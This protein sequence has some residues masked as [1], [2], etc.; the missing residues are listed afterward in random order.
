MPQYGLIRDA[1]FFE[2]LEKEGISGMLARDSSTLVKAVE[3]SCRNKAE[4][5]A[6]DEKEGGI[7]ATL[8]LGHTFGH[9][10]ETKSGYGT[11]LH[12]EAVAIGT[13]MA[14]DC[15]LRLKWID[16]E[17]HDRAL[18]LLKR[19]NLPVALPLHSPLDVASFEAIMAVDKKVANG[20]LRLILLQGALGNCVFTKDYDS[21]AL[22][23]TLALFCADSHRTS[24]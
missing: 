8:N 13:A 21:K 3:L 12:G 15:S 7:R 22:K 5:V 23:Q 11:W 14:L 10:I 18:N 9:A 6:L 2:W 4:V 17:L 24:S 20:A 19:A 1:P 16:Q